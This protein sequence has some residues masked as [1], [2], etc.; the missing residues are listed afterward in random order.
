MPES[1]S[2]P[3]SSLI[4]ARTLHV[5]RKGDAPPIISLPP[6]F[7]PDSE[8]AAYEVQNHVAALSGPVR[9]WKV[10]A[11]GPDAEPSAA[12]LHAETLFTDGVILPADFFNHRGVEAEIAYR[13][14]RA[15]GTDLTPDAVLSAIGSVHPAIEVVDTR[16]IAP[17]TQPRLAHMADQQ[18][19]GALILGPAFSDWRRFD[20][21]QE[22][23]V[24]RIDHRRVSEQIGGNAAGDLTRLLIWLAAHAARRGLPIEAGTIVTTGS[25]SGAFFVPHRTHVSVQFDTLGTVT[26]FL[27]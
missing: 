12:P 15:V 14:D 25:L 3:T 1:L 7:I 10:G 2:K 18:N 24:M 26:A 19:H 20:P 17:D 6:H 16:F 8:E 4:L 5:V 13:F 11:S 27:E 23:F 21:A 9:G 22:K